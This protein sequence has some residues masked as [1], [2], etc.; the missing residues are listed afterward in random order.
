M[1]NKIVLR[2]FSKAGKYFRG[3]SKN[4]DKFTNSSPIGR[5]RIEIAADEPF[6]NLK[7]EVLS[8]IL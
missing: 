6:S 8:L 5:S 2:V 3:F 4:Y 1:S 7:S